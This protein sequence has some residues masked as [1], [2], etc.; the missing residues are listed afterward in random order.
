MKIRA[1]FAALAAFLPLVLG[2]ASALAAGV[3]VSDGCATLSGSA[4]GASDPVTVNDQGTIAVTGFSGGYTAGIGACDPLP[5]DGK[6]VCT[7][8]ASNTKVTTGGAVTLYARCTAGTGTYNWNGS[9]GSPVLPANPSSNKAI[10]LTFSNPGSYTYTVTGISTSGTTGVKST[11]L[12]IL[13]GGATDAP[14]CALTV[15]PALVQLS[16]SATATVSC[17]PEATSY[18]WAPPEPLSPAFTGDASTQSFFNAG[19]FTYDVQGSNA[20]GTGPVASASVTVYEGSVVP[21]RPRL[22]AASTYAWSSGNITIPFPAG[23]TS[24]DTL[25]LYVT[26]YGNYSL[27]AGWTAQ[28]GFGW[29]Y[30]VSSWV[31]TRV[32]GTATSVTLTATANPLNGIV[33]I[34]A[35]Q[36]VSAVGAVG[37]F[38]Q[39]SGA[40]LPLPGI[41]LMHP[42]SVVLGLAVDRGTVSPL[43]ANDFTSR[44]AF[45][46]SYWG[47]RLAEK[48]YNATGATGAASWTQTS[49]LLDAA[50]VLIELKP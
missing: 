30:A 4:S 43:P 15:A 32:A 20:Q 34:A 22:R 17:H 28:R 35:Y 26:T 5:A 39:S 49:D 24:T 48:F 13:V 27:P 3:S 6:P 12:T 11:P 45:S 37:T 21:G 29:T 36:N 41:T 31:F 10:S 33:M 8:S 40:S 25:V 7:L 18:V 50:G 1:H 19:T 14:T 23:T 9:A 42:G 38:Q 47:L 46:T 16:G 2:S 44:A